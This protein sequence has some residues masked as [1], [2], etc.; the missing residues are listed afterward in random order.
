MDSQ[1]GISNAPESVK[2][3]DFASLEDGSLVELIEDPENPNRTLFA[4][5]RD[6][7]VQ[8]V[9]KLA[10]RDHILIPI[11]RTN[12]VLSHVRLPR[13]ASPYASVQSLLEDIECFISGSL[14]LQ[15]G[16]HEV[17]ANFVLATWLVDRLPVA[18]YVLAVGLAQSGKTTL[19]EV[20]SFLCRRPVLTADISS[21]AFYQACALLTPTLLIDEAGSPTNLNALRHILR[22]GTTRSVRAMRKNQI[23]HAFGAKVLSWPE[24]PDDPA[25]NSR[26]ILLPMVE[27][28][29]ADLVRTTDPDLEKR[30]VELQNSF[31]Q[32]RFE[33]YRNVHLPNISGTEELGPRARDLFLSVAAPSA[34]DPERCRLLLSNFK[35]QDRMSREPLPLAQHAVLRALFLIIHFAPRGY[36]QIKDLT[37]TVNL[38]L[39]DSHE[40]FRLQP[41]KVGAALTSL[42]FWQRERTNYGWT[43]GIPKESRE[44]IHRLA[45]IYGVDQGTLPLPFYEC[46]TCDRI[47]LK[48]Y[49]HKWPIDFD[50]IMT[51][52]Q[53]LNIFAEEDNQDSKAT[54]ELTD[55]KGASDPQVGQKA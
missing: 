3:V 14:V 13:G 20:L 22:S 29:R 43:V 55:S 6:G 42:G 53:L 5:W 10:Y 12:P 1:D 28:N 46:Q 25:L 4:V 49:V 45:K 36:V 54:S 19:L 31:L 51:L 2:E 8:Y 21:A 32:F 44:R 39:S 7:E 33:K 26:C 16:Q 40:G 27:S 38:I 9:D 17:L 52:R 34:E 23:L 50:R 11:P 35:I 24:L 47:G 15:R 41:R 18:P 30:A 48:P 37:T